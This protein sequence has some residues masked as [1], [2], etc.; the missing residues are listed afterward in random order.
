MQPN[1]FSRREFVALL[2]K[3]LLGLSGL[4]GL[5]AVT[6]YLGFQVE[7][8][9]PERF[10]LGPAQQFAPGSR[11]LIPQA[12]AVVVHTAQGLQAY[13]LVCPH[14]GCTVQ[15]AP[16]GFDCPCHGSQ[17]DAAGVVN[18]GPA[19]KNLTPLRLEQSASGS[20][21]LHLR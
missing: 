1:R 5:K 2:G 16:G 4:L 3:G 6:D 12:R 14:L 10:E 15:L 13:S 8:P 11:T 7:P 9:Q 20:L 17:F 18:R 19:N 21:I